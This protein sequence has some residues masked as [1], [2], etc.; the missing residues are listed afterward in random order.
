MLEWLLKEMLHDGDM[1]NIA[2]FLLSVIFD[3]Q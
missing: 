2:N 3:Y 1:V